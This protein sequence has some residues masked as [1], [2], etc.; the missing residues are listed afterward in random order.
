MNKKQNILVTWLGLTDIRAAKEAIGGLGPIGQAAVDRNF[1]DILI[2]SNSSSK[3]EEIYSSWL[4]K[5]TEARVQ[6]FNFTLSSPTEYGEIFEAA[7]AVI[8]EIKSTHNN[9]QFTYHL[10]PGTPAMSAVWIMMAKSNYPAELIDSSVQQGVRTV[11]IPVQIYAT[12]IL[13]DKRTDK[14]VLD[15]FD[16]GKEDRTAFNDILYNSDIM[17]IQIARAVKVSKYDFPVLILGESGTGKELFTKAIHLAS[18]RKK[19]PLKC[20]NCGAIPP[21]L[22]E[23][24]LFGYEK[25]AFTGANNSHKG[26]IESANGGTLFLDEIGEMPLDV[27]VKL[28]RTLQ[29]KSITRIGSTDE[30][31]I[32]FRVI[33]ATNRNLTDEIHK[34][35]FRE[36]LFHRLA[37][38]IINLPTL[39][40]RKED[41]NILINYFLDILIKSEGE[42]KKFSISARNLMLK[43]EWPGNIREL[44][45]TIKR[46]FIWSA[47]DTIIDKDVKDNLFSV[48]RKITYKDNIYDRKLGS[49]FCLNRLIEDIEKHYI[50]KA[51][52]MTDKKVKA[53]ELLGYKNHQ[54][55]NNKIEKLFLK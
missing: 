16:L 11:S 23:A 41:I 30:I 48:S 25:G 17:K 15:F 29:E 27:Q 45:N 38:G 1:S 24:E 46:I 31:K 53:A 3:D 44:D 4:C 52:A 8:E 37:I 13:E 6:V 14:D 54:T 50:K 20:V 42:S 36:D 12:H 43:Y 32:D 9:I 39:R 26:I 28:L 21:N 49:D 7:K 47:G 5:R 51:L 35:R 10:S 19:R 55:L 18:R 2:I 33:A 34:G 40:D 22:I